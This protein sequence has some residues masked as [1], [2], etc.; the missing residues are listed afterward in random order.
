MTAHSEL[1]NQI[2]LATAEVA[3]L[4]NNEQGVAR[5]NK[6]GRKWAVTYGVGAGGGDLLGWRLSDGRFV[7]IEVKVG[8]DERST[9]QERW[10]RWVKTGHGLSG[11]A[12]SI[13]DALD[14]IA[15]GPGAPK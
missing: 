7:S 9:E 5:Y 8:R 15:G 14:I 10:D 12:R 11:V 1:R 2:I 4:F 3:R 13:E 6:G